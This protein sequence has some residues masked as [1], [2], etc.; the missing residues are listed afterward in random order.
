MHAA[1]R[2]KLLDMA[3]CI[4]NQKCLF[5][6]LSAI[7]IRQSLSVALKIYYVVKVP[8]IPSEP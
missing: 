3:I 1:A 5:C 4:C 8:S 7:T 6:I 2:D